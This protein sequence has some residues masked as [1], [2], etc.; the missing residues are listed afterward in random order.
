MGSLRR[1]LD[2]GDRDVAALLELAAAEHARHVRDV[3]QE[4]LRRSPPLE[5]IGMTRTVARAASMEWRWVGHGL[6][7]MTNPLSTLLHPYQLIHESFASVWT[8][9]VDGG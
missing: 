2:L 6:A 5:G 3:R 9:S 1:T 7:L 4:L 8:P